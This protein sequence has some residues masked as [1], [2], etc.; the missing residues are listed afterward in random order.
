MKTSLLRYI[1]LAMSGV[2][3]EDLILE[4][5]RA[6]SALYPLPEGVTYAYG[7][8]GFRCKADLLPAVAYR[9]GILA[10]IR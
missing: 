6:S 7:T 9:I 2:T 5:V 1:S 4:G 3:E 10:A 8:A